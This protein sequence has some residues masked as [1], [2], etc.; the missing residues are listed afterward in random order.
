MPANMQ[1]NPTTSTAK[2]DK[3]VEE[4]VQYTPL[5]RVSIDI[6]RDLSKFEKSKYNLV[7]KDKD[8]I[9]IPSQIDTVTLFGEVFNPISFVYNDELDG[10]DY[11][12]LASGY[13]QG[14]DKNSVYVIHADGTSEPIQR[15]WWIF[16]FHVDI[17][18]GDTIVVPLYIQE[19]SK[20]KVWDS[21][22]KIMAS[23]ALTA[24]SLSTLGLF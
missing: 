12:E 18:K 4:A 11:I 13:T 9:T 8:T 7:L 3:I 16:S 2:L 24:A 19:Y 6:D 23:F 10:S 17:K 14:A 20:L 21:V 15:G 1:K 5:G 22:S